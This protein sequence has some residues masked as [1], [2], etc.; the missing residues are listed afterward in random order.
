M[1]YQDRTKSKRKY[2]KILVATM[3]PMIL[4]GTA[5]S[6]TIAPTAVYA[7]EAGTVTDAQKQDAVEK[8][9]KLDQL[10]TDN[11][12]GTSNE[13]QQDFKDVMNKP[14]VS[15]SINTVSKIAPEIFKAIKNDGLIP[16]EVLNNIAKNLVLMGA[17][18]I[19][20]VGGVVSSVIGLIW[21]GMT[22]PNQLQLLEQKLTSLI[23]ER[24]SESEKNGLTASIQ[25]TARNMAALEGLVKEE[26][27]AK[28]QSRSADMAKS[29]IVVINNSLNTILEIA[30]NSQ[31]K[32]DLLPLYTTAATLHLTFLRYLEA[33]VTNDELG[34]SKADYN[35]IKT[36][37]GGKTMKELAI[38]YRDFINKTAEKL[39]TEYKNT[40]DKASNWRYGNGEVPPFDIHLG[41]NGYL[42]KFI[43]Y[44]DA[45]ED[46]V[47]FKNISHAI[48]GKEEIVNVPI[49]I[50]V[51]IAAN[52]PKGQRYL[53]TRDKDFSWVDCDADG[54][55]SWQRYT[56][57]YINKSEN[58]VAIRAESNNHYISFDHYQDKDSAG[59]LSDNKGSML[60]SNTDSDVTWIRLIS[61]KDGN[62]NVIPDQYAMKAIH[63]FKECYIYAD[64][65]ANGKLTG[66]SRMN[67]DWEKFTIKKA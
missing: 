1:N 36:A 18:M 51:S 34:M 20:Y 48:I 3:A 4:V 16:P 43:N 47:P 35:S 41:S 65:N 67:G 5:G 49:G 24:V 13:L 30:K 55:G 19:P 15:F 28:V 21:P 14:E 27:E 38:Q 62:G 52:G 53:S 42:K 63:S 60:R 54:V 10:L 12:G 37:N 7:A 46:N 57:E 58:I 31:Y 26:E 23:N 56:I 8:I 29:Y 6:F 22:G 45:T 33:N 2:K 17:Q 61:L 64:F 66:T 50:P 9:N 32:E 44:A 59:L 25:A 39:E 11:V 40:Y